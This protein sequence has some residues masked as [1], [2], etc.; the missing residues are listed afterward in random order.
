MPTIRDIAK[1]ANVSPATVSRVLNLDKT[2]SVADKTKQRIFEVAE[3][4]NYKPTKKN[5]VRQSDKTFGVV[6][7]YPKNKELT[8]PYFL[9]I[10][11]GIERRCK[12]HNIKVKMVYNELEIEAKT[13]SDYR[14]TLSK[15]D[16]LILMGRFEESEVDEFAKINSNICIVDSDPKISK[17]D[18]VV[19]DF[20]KGTRNVI[21]C[22]I[23]AGHKDIGLLGARNWFGWMKEPQFVIDERVST[24]HEY[25]VFLDL[26]NEDFVRI[27]EFDSESGYQMMN[28]MLSQ[29]KYPS[30]IFASSDMIAIGA[31]KAI[32]EKGL[33]IP[34][35]ISIIG[36]DD[37]PMTDYLTPALTTT[38]IYSEFMGKKAVD[39]LLDRIVDERS[40]PLKMLVPTEMVVKGSTR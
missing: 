16:G 14:K 18:T 36:F 19:I 37:I 25:M 13:G 11:M 39:L 7:L 1:K 35:D 6:S 2:L 40:I 8:D 32:H 21:D 31:M 5:K 33:R 24:F 20:P 4:L 29:D 30:A 38:K 26:Y 23:E 3:E 28:D 15:K 27:G 12:D 17:Y 34:E 9:S 22:F 10:R